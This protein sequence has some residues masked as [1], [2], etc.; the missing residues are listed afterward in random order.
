MTGDLCVIAFAMYI[1]QLCRMKQALKRMY[2][3]IHAKR[4]SLPGV[5]QL[6]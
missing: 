2:A 3:L 1:N 5:L 6:L 4:G